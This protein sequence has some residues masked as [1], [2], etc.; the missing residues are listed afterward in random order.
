MKMEK[1]KKMKIEK[2]ITKNE[3]RKK[4]KTREINKTKNEKRKTKN[5]KEKKN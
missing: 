4:Y 5:E 1:N 2:Q 3:K